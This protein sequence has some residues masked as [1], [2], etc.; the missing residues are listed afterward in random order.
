MARVI[1]RKV[2]LPDGRTVPIQV[3][4]DATNDE[5][6]DF[7]I[8][9]FDAG[10]WPT[11][12]GVSRTAMTASPKA[13]TPQGDF[14]WSATNVAGAVLDPLRTMGLSAAQEAW[15]GLKAIPDAIMGEDV[16]AGIEETRQKWAPLVQPQTSGGKVAMQALQSGL[17]STLGPEG[18]DVLGKGPEMGQQAFERFAPQPNT[19]SAIMGA[20]YQTLPDLLSYIAGYG[21]IK[22]AQGMVRLKNADGTPTAELE[23]LLAT[24]GLS[25]PALSAEVRASLPVSVPREIFGG[26]PD[27]TGKQVVGKELGAGGTQAGLARFEQGLFGRTKTDPLA[28]QGIKL[29]M[30]EGVI[31]MVKTSDPVTRFN[32]QRILKDHEAKTFNRGSDADPYSVVGTALQ[33]RVKFLDQK[34]AEASAKLDQVVSTRLKGM[35]VNAAPLVEAFYKGLDDLNVRYTIDELGAPRFGDDAF[36]TS[37]IAKDS[38]SIKMIKD[39]ADLLMNRADNVADAQSL[40]LLKRQLDALIDWNK[41]PVGGIP[42][43]GRNFVKGLRYESNNILRQLDDDYA[44]ANDTLSMVLDAKGDLY[45]SLVRSARELA[46]MDDFAAAGNDLRKLFTNYG[47]GYEQ[48]AALKGIDAAVNKLLSE[49]TGTGRDV[50]PQGTQFPPR[51]DAP[52]QS[53]LYNMGEVI[54]ELDRLIGPTKRGSFQGKVAAGNEPLARSLQDQKAMWYEK[55]YQKG[56]ERFRTDNALAERQRKLDVYRVLQELIQRGQ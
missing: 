45:D 33:S 37:V 19:G 29:D 4:S 42:E 27:L 49:R 50:V 17:Q 34:A 21:G 46:K 48:V 47:K 11:E 30:D 53:S 25:Y 41:S 1:E 28:M 52:D 6:L 5:I 14:P 13:G 2:Q 51:I 20:T 23:A 39:A 36:S 3:P 43:K 26:R 7:V 10:A 15:A 54:L 16:R 24:Q 12:E 38:G 55:L 22:H 31:Q 8:E 44:K 56:T 35:E 32:M 9:Q 40:H 18:L